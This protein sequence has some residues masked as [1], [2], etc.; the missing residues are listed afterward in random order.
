MDDQA[1]QR[2]A[3]LPG[4]A[5]R[6]EHDGARRQREVGRRGDDRRVVPAELQ[7]APPEAPGDERG[8]R[9]AHRRRAGR[10]EQRQS[11]VVGHRHRHVGAAVHDLDEI[12]RPA[13]TLQQRG[14]G[15]RRQRRRRARLPHHRIPA[16]Q[17]DRR[18]PRPHR[19][20]EVEGGDDADRSKGLPGLREAVGRAFRGDRSAVQLA[21]QADGEVADVDHL[22]H[23]TA[24]LGGDL[25][26]LDAD[27]GGQVIEVVAHE[28]AEP[29]HDL[30]ADGRRCRAPRAER[31]HRT[32]EHIVE[33]E[34]RTERTEALA[35]DRRTRRRGA[36]GCDTAALER[37]DGERSEVIRGRQHR[38]DR[39]SAPAGAQ[40]H[41]G[42]VRRAGWRIEARLDRA[43]PPSDRDLGHIDRRPESI[44]ATVL[45]HPGTVGRARRRIRC[46]PCASD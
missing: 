40:D 2:R 9:R 37:P 10:A 18:V 30:A 23:L 3:P 28:V 22:L 39:V 1:A 11:S 4:G 21:G 16:H 17:G 34:R 35:R 41:V 14:A 31:R 6:G 36:A 42:D 43:P 20:R 19:C 25:A 46:A 27:Q 29:A 24:R 5:G 12:G 38:H 26:D 45:G 33:V 15:E 13:G 7:Q 44:R 8:E 32:V